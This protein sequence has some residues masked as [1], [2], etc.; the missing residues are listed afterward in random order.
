M[1]A[2]LLKKNLY[3]IL[4]YSHKKRKKEE[5]Y[6]IAFQMLFT[7]TIDELRFLRVKM[8]ITDFEKSLMNAISKIIN[9]FFYIN[10]ML[11]TIAEYVIKL[12][13]RDASIY[14]E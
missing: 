2:N 8:F 9:S 14:G 1:G 12:T 11:V 5:D 4:S 3:D 10:F 6:F 7:Q 13:V